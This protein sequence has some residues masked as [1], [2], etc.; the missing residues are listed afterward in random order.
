[1]FAAGT[2]IEVKLP[3]STEYIHS[4]SAVAAT[5]VVRSRCALYIVH[6]TETVPHQCM[7]AAAL[8]EVEHY[9]Y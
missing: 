6:N 7:S 4:W 5:I 9:S 3:D 1:M 8:S 2:L